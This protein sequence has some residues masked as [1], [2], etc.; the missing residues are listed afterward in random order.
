MVDEKRPPPPL[1]FN[2]FMGWAREAFEEAGT[3]K[4]VFPF[5]SVFGMQVHFIGEDDLFTAKVNE[6]LPLYVPKV[7]ANGIRIP[8]GDI[9]VVSCVRNSGKMGGTSSI[10]EGSGVWT[11]DRVREIPSDHLLVRKIWEWAP[12]SR[13]N[14]EREVRQWFAIARFQATPEIRPPLLVLV[15]GFTA[16]KDDGTIG[17]FCPIAPYIGRIFKTA[18]EED[19]RK[20]EK[21]FAYE[22]C[23]CLRQIAAISYLDSK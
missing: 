21:S 15:F 22:C 2:T 12:K 10:P 6:A 23:E 4:E 20:L 1:D 18:S 16:M 14:C 3:V 8:Y 7:Q 19:I 5:D 17:G 9:A 13:E 11:L